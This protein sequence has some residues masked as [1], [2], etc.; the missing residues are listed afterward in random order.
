MTAMKLVSVAYN[1][2]ASTTTA[3][4]LSTFNCP[5]GVGNTT[6]GVTPKYIPNL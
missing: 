2:T 6:V 5:A 1:I 4:P 3:D